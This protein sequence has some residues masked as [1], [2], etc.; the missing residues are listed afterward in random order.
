MEDHRQVTVKDTQTNKDRKLRWQCHCQIAAI[1]RSIVSD[2]KVHLILI[3]VQPSKKMRLLN[4]NVPNNITG[5]S[6]VAHMVKH[7]TTVWETWVRSL[8]QEDPLEKEM[9]THSS[10]HAWK[11]TW[12]EEPGR[13]PSMGSQRVVHD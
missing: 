11:I 4:L 12:T 1:V 9:A 2:K 6:L 7:L 8:G 5:A 13:L 10:I 3:Q